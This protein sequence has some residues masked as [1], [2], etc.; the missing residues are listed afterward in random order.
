MDFHKKDF[1]PNFKGILDGI[2]VIDVSRLV[3][4]NALT[5]MLADFGAEVIKI[6]PLT[7][8][9]FRN[10]HV[11]AVPLHWKE[12]CRNKKSL[13]LNLRTD[14]G[15]EILHRLLEDAD[16]FV[17]NFRPGRLEEFGFAPDKI[18]AKNEKLIVV[19]LSGYGQTGPYREYGGF[20]TLV[21]AMSG[22]ASRNGFADR[23]PVLPPLAMAD[24]I[25]GITGAMATSMALYQRDFKGGK[26]QVSDVSLLEPLYMILGPEAAR[27]KMSGTVRQRSGSS[28]QTS[29]PRGVYE[30]K[31]GKW[32]SMSASIQTMAHRLF[33]AIGREDMV[34][35]PRYH[36]NADR[37]QRREEVD[38]IVGGFIKQKT[39]DENLA[40]FRKNQITVGP[41]FDISQIVEDEHFKER[42]IIVDLPDDDLEHMPMHNVVP[43]LS[44]TPGGFKRPAPA[45]GEHNAEILG[46]LGYDE[47]GLDK[48]R[49]N[50][51]II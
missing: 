17:E 8:D 21:E 47:A 39:L 20:G 42:E 10:W 1:D 44:E 31:D 3:A 2:R 33:R 45:I 18:M 23:E 51:V 15:K 36:T 46:E 7:G 49:E 19:R 4:G 12:Y 9:P 29:C 25:A 14:E 40:F 34:D 30:T 43:R 22:F 26:G 48:L 27:Y 16:C 38:G 37:I 50:N 5:K 41:V 28:S 6:E 24:M 11:S 32:V 35:D 13:S